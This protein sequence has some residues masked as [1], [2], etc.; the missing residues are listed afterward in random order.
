LFAI[1]ALEELQLIREEKEMLKEIRR[2]M[3][4]E[5]KEEAVARAAKEL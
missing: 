5:E 4:N 3:K 2:E 1:R